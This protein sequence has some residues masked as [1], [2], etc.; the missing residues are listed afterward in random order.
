VVA[1]AMRTEKGIIAM[2]R[3]SKEWKKKTWYLTDVHLKN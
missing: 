3:S 1:V 2:E